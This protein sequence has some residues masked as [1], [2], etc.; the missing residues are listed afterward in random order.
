MY[1]YFD[2]Q[3]PSVPLKRMSSTVNPNQLLKFDPIEAEKRLRIFWKRRAAFGIERAAIR[4]EENIE[5]RN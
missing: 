3:R 5:R 1:S 4:K 2:L